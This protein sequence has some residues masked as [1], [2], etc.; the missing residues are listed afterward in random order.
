ME[1]SWRGFADSLINTA[2]SL[3]KALIEIFVGRLFKPLLG[4]FTGWADALFGGGGSLLKT[5]AKA[6][7]SLGTAAATTAA[8]TAGAIT[9]G[10]L[11]AAGAVAL[12]AGLAAGG[13]GLASFGAAPF[14]TTA[15]T[16]G[17]AFG[18]L[19]AFLTNP[20]TIGAAAA[21]IG[22]YALYKFL[23][24]PNRLGS[25]ETSRDFGISIGKGQIKNFLSSMGLSDAFKQDRKSILSSPLFLQNVL[26]PAAQQGGQVQ[27]LISAFSRLEAFGKTF[28]F[29]AAVTEALAGNF[30]QFNEQFKNVF[31]PALGGLTN[32]LLGTS[33]AT[34][35]QTAAT[36]TAASTTAQ[37]TTQTRE[38]NT[39]LSTLTVTINNLIESIN[40]WITSNP[41]IAPA[42][43]AD[44]VAAVDQQGAG[45]SMVVVD[46]G[47]GTKKGTSIEVPVKFSMGSLI[48]ILEGGQGGYR[49]RMAEMVANTQNG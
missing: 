37:T 34:Q 3:A 48:D 36:E 23:K 13:A 35:Q 17:S 15:G 14:A 47:G 20:F 27:Q 8:S 12:P 11:P 26:G 49:E 44:S 46:I 39:R 6:A 1:F 28:D 18:S 41:A 40:N 45:T 16:G 2:R 24:N 4:K 30:E 19:G 31:G 32:Q 38:L 10:G 21:G 5:G 42:L 43:S 25:K 9:A 22:G 33:S 7:F 29:S